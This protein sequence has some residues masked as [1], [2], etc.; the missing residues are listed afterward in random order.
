MRY[1][2]NVNLNTKN[3]KPKASIPHDEALIRELR[4]NLDLAGQ[5]L[6]ATLEEDSDLAC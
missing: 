3:M 6:K 4:D 2:E 5:Y 1:T